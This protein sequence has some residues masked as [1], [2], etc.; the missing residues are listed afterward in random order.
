MWLGR[1]E[2]VR[3]RPELRGHRGTGRVRPGLPCRRGD[4]AFLWGQREAAGRLGA[5]PDQTHILGLQWLGD[6]SMAWRLWW[7]RP[8]GDSCSWIGKRCGWPTGSVRVRWW[9]QPP[10]DETWCLGVCSHHHVYFITFA[11]HCLFVFTVLSFLFFIQTVPSL[12]PNS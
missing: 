8:K 1:R 6:Q 11:C 3:E 2:Q 12:L 4:T 7:E 9:P 5:R 10:P